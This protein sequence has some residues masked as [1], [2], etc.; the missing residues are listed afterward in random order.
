MENISRSTL[1]FIAS[2]GAF[3]LVLRTAI[4]DASFS[5]PEEMKRGSIIGNLAKDMSLDVRNLVA[6]KARLETGKNSK[7]YC[8]LNLSTGDVIVSDRIDR[9]VL[10]GKKSSCVLIQELVL[11]DP[12]EVHRISLHVQDINDNSPQFKK[13]TIKFEIRES[14][15]KHSNFRLD[16]AFDADIGLNAIHGYSLEENENFSL[17]VVAKSGGGKYSELVLKKELDREQ[18]QELTVVLVATDGGSPQRSGTAVIHV[19]VLD[20]ND[21]TPVFSQ[22][23]YKASLTENSP[24]D[25]VVVTVSATDADEGVNGDD[26]DESFDQMDV[27]IL[28]MTPEGVSPPTSD[29]HPASLKIVI[30]GEAVVERLMTLPEAVGLLFGLTYGLHLNYPK[31]IRNTLLVIPQ[32]F[33]HLEVLSVSQVFKH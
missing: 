32:I 8:D 12:L 20:A 16:E 9:E 18:Q 11:E 4:G 2:L 23:V 15:V 1:S 22:A 10:C 7:R 21:N 14:A 5:F 13:N 31:K 26:G 25:T 17:K 29:L 19:S 6:R 30:E 3:C 24:L 28:L 27:G 33:F